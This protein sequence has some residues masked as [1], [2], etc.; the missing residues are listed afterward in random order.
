VTPLTSGE[1]LLLL[2]NA[3]ERLQRQPNA[4]SYA[5]LPAEV[6]SD[7]RHVR[8]LLDGFEAVTVAF[9]RSEMELI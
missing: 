6:A 7:C 9:Y 4:K 1:Y 8:E 5:D 3:V 2:R